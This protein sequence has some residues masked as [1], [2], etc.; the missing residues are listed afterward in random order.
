MS[1]FALMINKEIWFRYANLLRNEARSKKDQ[2]KN[3]FY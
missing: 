1:M 3:A 2:S